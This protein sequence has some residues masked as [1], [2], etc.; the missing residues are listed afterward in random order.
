MGLYDYKEFLNFGDVMDY[1]RDKNVFSFYLDLSEY[2]EFL[3]SLV[4]QKKITPIVYFDSVTTVITYRNEMFPTK[5]QDCIDIIEPYISGYFGIDFEAYK[6]LIKCDKITT[7]YVIDDDDDDKLQLQA[8]FISSNMGVGGSYKFIDYIPYKLNNFSYQ[9]PPQCKTL[10]QPNADDI[11]VVNFNDVVYP[12]IELDALFDTEEKS[13]KVAQNEI[14]NLKNE[15]IKVQDTIK[16]LQGQTNELHPRTT[17]NAAKVIAC[18]AEL[19]SIDYTKPNGQASN[20]RILEIADRLGIE[21][22]QKAIADWLKQA[23]EQAR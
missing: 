4:E 5:E 21:L 1:L 23:H 12:K 8:Y 18:L 7:E 22:S 13:D 19:A 15:L 11:T 14:A 17:N 16:K 10:Y 3:L 9:T 6:R 2:Q 20:G